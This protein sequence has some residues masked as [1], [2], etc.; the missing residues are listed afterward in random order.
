M[1]KGR[2]GKKYKLEKL[3]KFSGKNLK[4]LNDPG[5]IDMVEFPLERMGISDDK[6]RSFVLQKMKTLIQQREVEKEERDPDSQL[7]DDNDNAQA[8]QSA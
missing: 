2:I 1:D 6:D 5:L 4:V 7:H 8:L 3:E